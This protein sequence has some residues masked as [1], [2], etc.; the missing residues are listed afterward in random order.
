MKP[1]D[2]RKL[3]ELLERELV[4]RLEKRYGHK[5][6][7]KADEITQ[8][9]E[10]AQTKCRPAAADQ[11]GPPKRLAHTRMPEIPVQRC[12]S[13]FARTRHSQRPSGP[14]K[15]RAARGKQGDLEYTIACQ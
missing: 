14:E 4:K 7:R 12:R 11:L 3:M 15:S 9:D 1:E 8:R 5:A 6:T 13:V 2:E 10:T